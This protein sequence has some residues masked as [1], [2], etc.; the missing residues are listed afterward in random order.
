MT[1]QELRDFIKAY[2]MNWATKRALYDIVDKV[3]NTSGASGI[4]VAAGD[5]GLPAGDLQEVLQ[6]LADRIADLEP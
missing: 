5:N 1:F 3:E 6:S 2:Y 4:E